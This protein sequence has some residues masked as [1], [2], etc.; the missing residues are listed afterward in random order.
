[1]A[2]STKMSQ[3]FVVCRYVV[4]RIDTYI[5]PLGRKEKLINEGKH[6]IKL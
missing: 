2:N 1:M 3:I 4:D 5:F 6:Q